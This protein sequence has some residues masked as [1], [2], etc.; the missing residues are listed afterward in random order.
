MERFF[1][2][3][4]FYIKLFQHTWIRDTRD[5]RVLPSAGYLVKISHV[6]Q[7]NYVFANFLSF[8]LTN[9]ISAIEIDSLGCF[10]LLCND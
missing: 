7:L 10:S 4:F 5:S 1:S 6:S 9:E 3:I 8:I 2:F